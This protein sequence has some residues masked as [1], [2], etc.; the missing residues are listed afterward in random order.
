MQQIIWKHFQPFFMDLN[1]DHNAK[2][3]PLIQNLTTLQL[4][5]LINDNKTLLIIRI[6]NWKFWLFKEAVSAYLVWRFCL[7]PQL[8][9]PQNLQVPL[10]LFSVLPPGIEWIKDFYNFYFTHNIW[11]LI[12][13]WAVYKNLQKRQTKKYFYYFNF[14]PFDD[15]PK[16]KRAENESFICQSFVWICLP[17]LLFS[18]QT[19]SIRCDVSPVSRS[20]PWDGLLLRLV[21]AKNQS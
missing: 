19:P 10:S 1:H 3:Y 8:V 18:L 11:Y 2:V 16:K 14:T 15:L 9:R 12:N 4:I 17:D 5:Y 21:S 6:F 13:N 20:W 7:C